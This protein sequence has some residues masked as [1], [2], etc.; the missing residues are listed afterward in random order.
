MGLERP[1]ANCVQDA[2]KAGSS[3]VLPPPCGCSIERNTKM[4]R[5]SQQCGC[6]RTCLWRACPR[7][8]GCTCACVSVCMCVRACMCVHASC[9]GG[10]GIASHQH[11]LNTKRPTQASLRQQDPAPVNR[12]GSRQGTGDLCARRPECKT[13]PVCTAGPHTH[14]EAG[15]AAMKEKRIPTAL[16]ASSPS[17][18]WGPGS[19]VI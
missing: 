16:P 15:S 13:V 12:R 5:E 6:V 10:G 19:Q 4:T 11:V 3:Q 2:W 18:S 17:S 1:T 7:G 8:S 9:M 14:R